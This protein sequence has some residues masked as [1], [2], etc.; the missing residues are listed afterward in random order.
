M[1]NVLVPSGVGAMSSRAGSGRRDAYLRV[2][3]VVSVVGADVQT[4]CDIDPE[5]LS[6]MLLLLALEWT[7]AT[8]QSLCLNDVAC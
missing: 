5:E 2:A 4:V 6:N 3:T 7:Q 8:S 1:T